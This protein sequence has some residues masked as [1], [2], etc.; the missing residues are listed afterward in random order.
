MNRHHLTALALAAMIGWAGRPASAQVRQI[1]GGN[2][3]DANPMVGS[4]GI[5][6]AAPPPPINRANALMTGRVGGGGGFQG[7]S[8][9]RDSSSFLMGLPSAGLSSFNAR[10]ISVA[11]VIAG[12]SNYQ[13]R[14]YYDPSRTVTNVGSVQRGLNRPG[15]SMPLSPYA[16]PRATVEPIQRDPISYEALNRRQATGHGM[17]IEPALQRVSPRVISGGM[18]TP[19]YT[20]SVYDRTQAVPLSDVRRWSDRTTAR[21]NVAAR[22]GDRVPFEVDRRRTTGTIES[23]LDSVLGTGRMDERLDYRINAGATGQPTPAPGAASPAPGQPT[24]VS[25]AAADLTPALPEPAMEPAGFG[26]DRFDDMAV[27]VTEARSR[28]AAEATHARAVQAQW[29]DRYLAQPVTSFVGTSETTLNRYLSLAEAQIHEGNYYRAARYYEMAGAMDPN[30][31][32]PFMGQAQALMAAG[33]YMT[34]VNLLCR[35]IEAFPAIAYFRI[36]L[37][38]FITD[39]LA[40]ERRRADLERLLAENDDYRLRFLLGYIEYFSGLRLPGLENLA[41]AAAKAPKG[42]PI[43]GFTELLK[44][45]MSVLAP[46]EP[47]SG[48][49]P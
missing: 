36:D 22:A 35:A 17:A 40:L 34:A 23:P 48:T 38:A 44:E 11:D 18:D 12:Q 3:L 43:A 25:P 46:A 49:S 21:P 37:N 10:G 5:N 4:G 30:S 9:I 39:G 29:V 8:P 42:S 1:Q 13:P 41:K 28:A 15:T 31:P 2:A 6:F 14:L 33:E 32:L 45:R 24:L 16:L 7:Y 27:I 47:A 20:G 19:G 26:Q